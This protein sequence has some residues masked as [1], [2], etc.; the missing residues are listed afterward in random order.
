MESYI[1]NYYR[2]FNVTEF[3]EITCGNFSRDIA[4]SE[5][6]SVIDKLSTSTSISKA[7]SDWC[8]NVKEYNYEVMLFDFIK[9]SV[10]ANILYKIINTDEALAYWTMRSKTTIMLNTDLHH[11]EMDNAASKRAL[12]ITTS[13]QKKVTRITN[14]K[15]KA[16]VSKVR[17]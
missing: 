6:E 8:R 9:C 12:A 17:I 3:L 16:D 4:M 14:M 15:R 7:L 11:S 1:T 10:Y 2:A 5:F 13:M